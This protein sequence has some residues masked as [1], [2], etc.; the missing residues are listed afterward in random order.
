MSVLAIKALNQEALT[1]GLAKAPPLEVSVLNLKH[2]PWFQDG[3][4]W[5]AMATLV[6]RCLTLED[7]PQCHWAVQL[8]NATCCNAPRDCKMSK[9]V[10]VVLGVANH[11]RIAQAGHLSFL[12]IQGEIAPQGPRFPI[13]CGQD[14]HVVVLCIW[15]VDSKQQEYVWYSDPAE[16]ALRWALY[17]AFRDTIGGGWKATFLTQ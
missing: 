16:M 13:V 15:G 4:C 3:W 17:P 14:G 7:L 6:H 1:E 11:L 12:D 10:D 9:E 5:A 8:I 2:E